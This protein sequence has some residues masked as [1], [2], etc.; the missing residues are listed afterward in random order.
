MLTGVTFGLESAFAPAGSQP[1]TVRVHAL[2][3]E[4]ALENLTLLGEKTI[5]V[6]NQEL[7]RIAIA[8]D[9]PIAV[10]PAT[11]IVAEVGAPDGNDDGNAFFAGGNSGGESAPAYWMSGACGAPEPIAFDSVGF[12][13][14]NLI[15]E[16]DTLAS[17]PCGT[18]ASPVDWLSIAPA[19]GTIAA[20]AVVPI[21]AQFAANA[22]AAGMQHGTLCLAP[23]RD[24]ASTVIV[25]AMLTIGSGEDSI[26]GNGFE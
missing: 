22:H 24:A 26:F 3:G 4:L 12:G 18:S 6:E 13:W 7:T 1:V 11:V 16:L 8:F 10:D 14:I 17:D 5:D 25:P 20:D 23:G 19:N 2:A 21:A 15:L 9:A